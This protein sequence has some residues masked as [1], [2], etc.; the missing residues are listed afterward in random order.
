MDLINEAETKA[1]EEQGG[2][3]EDSKKD[4]TSKKKLIQFVEEIREGGSVLFTDQY[5]NPFLAPSGNGTHVVRIR[6]RDFKNLLAKKWFEKMGVFAS[7]NFINE[8][9]YSFKR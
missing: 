5:K 8:A 9:Q 7:N 4:D 2:D 3:R 1:S 6:S